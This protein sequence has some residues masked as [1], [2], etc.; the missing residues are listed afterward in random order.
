MKAQSEAMTVAI[1]QRCTYAI[2]DSVPSFEATIVPTESMF[3][4]PT[5]PRVVA[6]FPD[7]VASPKD[8]FGGLGNGSRNATS[9]SVL[10]A[11]AIWQRRSRQ[12]EQTDT[13]SKRF[14]PCCSIQNSTKP[15]FT[16]HAASLIDAYSSPCWSY[17]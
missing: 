6:G 17:A 1:R 9:Q 7:L 16:V 15:F 13:K 2:S 11:I 8:T 12:P 10:R 14:Q 4:I 3:K 5:P